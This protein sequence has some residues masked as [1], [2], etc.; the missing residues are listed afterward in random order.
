MHAFIMF[1]KLTHLPVM[2]HTSVN[3]FSIASN[4]G[5]LPIQGQAIFL[6]NAGLFSI[7]PMRTNFSEIS[8]KKTFSFTK[9]DI[10][11]LQNYSLFVQEEMS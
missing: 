5:L 11:Y 7:Q 2:P 8:I 1:C 6:G 4:N 3:Q 9:M 10:K